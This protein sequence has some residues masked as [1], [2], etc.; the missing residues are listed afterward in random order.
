MAVATNDAIPV[1]ESRA[2]TDNSFAQ[3]R[4]AYNTWRSWTPEDTK[5]GYL[6]TDDLHETRALLL[7]NGISPK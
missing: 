5:P 3:T 7:A 1:P 2:A 6:L 4:P